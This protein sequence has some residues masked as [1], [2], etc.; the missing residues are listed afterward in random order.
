MLGL[1]CSSGIMLRILERLRGLLRT[2]YF[3]LDTLYD[4]PTHQIRGRRSPAI[5]TTLPLT[6]WGIVGAVP[7]WRALPALGIRF[8]LRPHAWPVGL[9]PPWNKKSPR[10]GGRKAHAVGVALT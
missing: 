3:H 8:G 7:L 10:S 2:R 4:T 5:W 6:R 9:S 1:L